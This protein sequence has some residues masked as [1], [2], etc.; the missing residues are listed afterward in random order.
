MARAFYL[1]ACCALA[2]FYGVVL[3]LTQHPHVSPLYRA[4]YIDRKLLYWNHGEG[5]RYTLGDWL[6]FR[7]RIPYLS[8]DGWSS[9]EDWGTWS[10]GETSS[11]LFELE[12]TDRPTEI[13]VIG[14][15][16]LALD[17]GITEQTISAFAN[18][19]PLGKVTLTSPSVDEIVFA[20]PPSVGLKD[21]NLLEVRFTYSKP[22]STAALG[23]S[24]D[25]RILGFGFGRL[26]LR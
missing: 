24:S 6:D 19:V 14:I 20:I 11:L 8:R 17:R 3:Y 26:V 16:F 15:P 9:P 4:Y 7:K 10:I 18:D 12:E 1:S 21:G 23:P 13:R 22:T 5:L 25:E 2:A